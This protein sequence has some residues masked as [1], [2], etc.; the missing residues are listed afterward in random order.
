MPCFSRASGYQTTNK[1][2]F[3]ERNLIL[4][5]KKSP[6]KCNLKV[7]E[8]NECTE[9]PHIILPAQGFACTDSYNYIQT[10]HVP[11]SQAA[12]EKRAPVLQSK[13]VKNHRL[14][15]FMWL[16]LWTTSFNFPFFHFNK[17]LN[18]SPLICLFHRETDREEEG[19][20][21]GQGGGWSPILCKTF[22][23]MKQAGERGWK[24]H[25]NPFKENSFPLK[26]VYKVG[27]NGNMFSQS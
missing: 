6:Q 26:S 5:T 3:N 10:A 14:Y 24:K 7:Q 21:E 4:S 18:T 15:I 9:K 17:S 27:P 8:H 13:R 11:L 25:K 12:G 19:V 20:S 1:S 22:G 23:F 16:L 2:H